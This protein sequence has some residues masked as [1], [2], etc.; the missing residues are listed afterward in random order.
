VTAQENVCHDANHPRHM[1]VLKALGLKDE[2]ERRSTDP[3]I[4]C[5]NCGAEADLPEYVCNPM[6]IGE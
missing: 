5:G 1:C 3:V 2:V 6:P 4:I